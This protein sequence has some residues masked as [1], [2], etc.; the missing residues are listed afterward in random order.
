MDGLE[1]VPT[2]DSD[3]FGARQLIPLMRRRFGGEG[4]DFGNSRRLQSGHSL[5]S[6]SS[7]ETQVL[8]ADKQS[9]R[10]KY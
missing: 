3:A 7:S 8:F 6:S 10:N 5:L 1:E 4:P 2:V 9:F